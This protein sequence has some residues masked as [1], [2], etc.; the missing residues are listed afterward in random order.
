MVSLQT[1]LYNTLIQHNVKQ[2]ITELI[3]DYRS[4]IANDIDHVDEDS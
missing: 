4:C 3:K 1:L 2:F